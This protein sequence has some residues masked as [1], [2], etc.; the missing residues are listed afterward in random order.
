[1]TRALIIGGGIGGLAAA[2]ALQRVGIE[3]AVF[4]KA[5]EITE[6]GAGL[7]L[8]SNAMLALQRLG[9]DAAAQQAGSIIDRVRRF[10]PNGEPSGSIDLAALGQLAGA[11]SICLHRATLQC[12]L[13]NAVI[14][15]DP[16]SVQTDRER[17][18]FETS[19]LS[20]SALF[21][22]GSREK[23]DV[24]IGADG[25]SIVPSHRNTLNFQCN[26]FDACGN[27]VRPIRQKL[28]LLILRG[29]FGDSRSA[30][31]RRLSISISRFFFEQP[32]VE[33]YLQFS[34]RP[35][36]G[37][38]PRKTLARDWSKRSIGTRSAAASENL[39][40]VAICYGPAN[41]KSPT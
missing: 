6:V 35:S 2:I 23:G 18:G 13:L 16:S 1:M 30:R 39:R 24:L 14:A 3:A 8:W 22:D 11:P 15:V 10:H 17:T 26:F 12:L 19:A 5:P 40:H 7:S 38:L 41:I 31:F 27:T 21:S 36:G 9:L 32:P 33:P 28:A 34:K 29:N 4:E 20:V 25:N 37:Y